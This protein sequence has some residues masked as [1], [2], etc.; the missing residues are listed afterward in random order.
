MAGDQKAGIARRKLIRFKVCI[1]G[2]FAFFFSVGY[3]QV[4]IRLNVGLRLE[5]QGVEFRYLPN[6]HY[7]YEDH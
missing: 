5:P 4:A 7:D 2:N 3:P 6:H 1:F